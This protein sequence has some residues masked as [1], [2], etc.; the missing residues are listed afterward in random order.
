MQRYSAD[1]IARKILYRKHD[2]TIG[3]FASNVLLQS[4]SLEFHRGRQLDAELEKLPGRTVQ[5]TDEA[6]F[7][8]FDP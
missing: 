6:L 2:N 1:M 8:I 7:S 4:Y 3:V 5:G